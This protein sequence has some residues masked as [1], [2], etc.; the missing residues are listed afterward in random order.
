MQQCL[1]A[2]LGP[3]TPHVR[4]ATIAYLSKIAFKQQWVSNSHRQ[5]GNYG[6][7][8]LS[9]ATV[10]PRYRHVSHWVML[11]LRSTIDTRYF[12]V[13]HS[14]YNTKIDA[15]SGWA[16]SSACHSGQSPEFG[17]MTSTSAPRAQRLSATST[18]PSF[19]ASCSG[20]FKSRVLQQIHMTS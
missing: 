16:D 7:I 1:Q 11:Q 3:R 10:A 19:I 9:Y 4:V 6:F 18:K 12:A 17:S 14:V 8:I 2:A 15:I 20:V 5:Y 13:S